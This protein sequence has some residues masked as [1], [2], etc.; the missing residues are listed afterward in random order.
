MDWIGLDWIGLD[1]IGQLDWI[2]WVGLD[3]MDWIGLDW[4]GL[5]WIGLDGIGLDW[6]GLDG[7]GLDSIA[8]G[9]IGL[10]NILP[11]SLAELPF[12]SSQVRITIIS[13]FS[14]KVRHASNRMEVPHS[15]VHTTLASPKTLPPYPPGPQIL[16]NRG[17]Y[18]K[19]SSPY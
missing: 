13:R 3:W 9:W 14:Q 10:G 19:G 18:Q 5:D 12:H 11:L 1:W 4:I 2:G 6:V 15:T 16:Q 17:G 8:L 7:M